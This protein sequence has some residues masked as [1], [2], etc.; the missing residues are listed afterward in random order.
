MKE[1]TPTAILSLGFIVITDSDG[2]QVYLGTDEWES[3]RTQV[4][5]MVQDRQPVKLEADRIWAEA[6]PKA[7]ERSSK[8]QLYKAWRSHRRSA[9]SL[10]F[11]LEA[12]GKWKKSQSWLDG[13]AE[14]IHR[15]VNN[16]RWEVEPEL[17]GSRTSNFSSSDVGI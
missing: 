9:P 13:Y 14:G 7:R 1:N 2:A 12:L 15:W 16:Q 5:E 17:V 4:D 8:A 11:V 6:P 3:L 10:E